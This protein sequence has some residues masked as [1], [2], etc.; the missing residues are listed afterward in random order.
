MIL[1]GVAFQDIF[2]GVKSFQI[3][4]AGYFLRI[5]CQC[6]DGCVILGLSVL[7]P[8]II[9][10]R[11]ELSGIIVGLVDAHTRF[12]ALVVEVNIRELLFYELPYI[13]RLV[14]C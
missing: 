3:L 6:F 11:E 9:F 2:A 4:R 13:I 14:P 12:L 7:D 8:E 5:V 10:L 1:S